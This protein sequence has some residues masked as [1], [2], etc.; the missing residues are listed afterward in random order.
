MV[1][2]D[3]NY[4]SVLLSNNDKK[5]FTGTWDDKI[6]IYDTE[7]YKK[8]HTL[9]GHTGSI[10]TMVLSQNE[11]ILYAGDS[12]DEIKVWDLKTY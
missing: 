4:Y 12:N 6:D 8:I 5:L 7:T 1:A 10:Y 2:E 9:I 3:E 11:D